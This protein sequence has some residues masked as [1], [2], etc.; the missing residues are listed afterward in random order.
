MKC[1]NTFVCQIVLLIII[2]F[3]FGFNLLVW[4]PLQKSLHQYLHFYIS[5]SPW[6]LFHK[7]LSRKCVG[8][9]DQIQGALVLITQ[10]KQPSAYSIPHSPIC[11]CWQGIRCVRSSCGTVI[12]QQNCSVQ[13]PFW[14]VFISLSP[15]LLIA[16]C[17]WNLSFL[18][19]WCISLKPHL[20][21]PLIKSAICVK[22]AFSRHPNTE[23]TMSKVRPLMGLYC[24]FY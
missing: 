16:S 5:V 6:S 10:G 22:E 19:E 9:S 13:S 7:V 14:R 15:K 21:R 18:C 3:T 24:T 11:L 12:F 20:T 17:D 4:K 2:G 1:C 8:R 23:I